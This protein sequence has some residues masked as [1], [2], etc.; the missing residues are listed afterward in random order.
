[1][2]A[3][4][5]RNRLIHRGEGPLTEAELVALLVTV[6]DLLYRARPV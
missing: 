1:V 5:K 2:V 4:G 6:G 3:T